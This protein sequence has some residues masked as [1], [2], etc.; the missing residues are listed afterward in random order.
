VTPNNECVK[1]ARNF[2]LR[3]QGNICMYINI[4]LCIYE[5]IFLKNLTKLTIEIALFQHKSL[6]FNK[7]RSISTYFVLTPFWLVRISM[8]IDFITH[9]HVVIYI[10]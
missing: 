4:C 7:N 10:K 9:Y 8:E 6:F 3:L 2:Q 1:K 5:F